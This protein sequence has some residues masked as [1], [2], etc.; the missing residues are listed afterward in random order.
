MKTRS[1]R[2][3]TKAF[4]LVE[5]LVA[6]AIGAALIAAA[7]V[8]FGV[9]SQIPFRQETENVTLPSGVVENFYGTN[10]PFLSLGSN[11][12]YFQ[13]VQARRMKDRLMDDVSSASAVFC[14]G[15]NAAGSPALRFREVPVSE[16][17]DFRT[18][19]TPGDFRRFLVSAVSALGPVF[20]AEQSGA[21]RDT[22][23]ASLFVVSGLESTRTQTNALRFSAIYE[24]DFVRT[25][26]PPG[27]TVAS[28]RR[29]SGTNLAVPTDYY[30]VHYAGE[31]NGNDGFRP[32]AAF[33]P[34]A[35]S[36]GDGND[37]YSKAANHPFTF[38][39]WPDPLVS[40]LGAS[41]F[42]AASGDPVRGN[43]ANMGGRTSLFFVLPAFPPL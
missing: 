36:D 39:W 15:R 3:K 31:T 5:V 9:I 2:R 38:V 4:T 1:R 28:V 34:R 29:Y 25:V 27:G 43:Y 35:E 32:L 8:G 22:T 6:A 26:D 16:G 13:S 41:D 7:V 23:N 14:L 19:A 20:P 17:E 37:P 33:F 18:N 40:K 12:N 42:P 24:V 21:L 10:L 11:P 30:H